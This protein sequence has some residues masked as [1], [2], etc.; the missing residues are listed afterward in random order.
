MANQKDMI[1]SEEARIM[2]LEQKNDDFHQALIRIDKR[3][4]SIDERFNKV[5]QRFDKIDEKFGEIR[6]EIKDVRKEMK[7]DFRWLLTIIAGL[8]AIMAHGFHWF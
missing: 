7:S 5:D 6:S 4:D 2:L 3:F 8:G 1:S